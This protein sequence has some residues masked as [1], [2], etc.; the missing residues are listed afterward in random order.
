[1]EASARTLHGDVTDII[2]FSFSCKSKRLYTFWEFASQKQAILKCT[3]FLTTQRGSVLTEELRGDIVVDEVSMNQI[4]RWNSSEA[5]QS[6]NIRKTIW[7]EICFGLGNLSSFE[8]NNWKHLRLTCHFFYVF[9]SQ[10]FE[11][12][13][14]GGMPARVRSLIGF[15]SQS[16]LGCTFIL[17]T[18]TW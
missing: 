5:T 12:R 13:R 16:P 14:L 8:G 10:I 15:S 3:V 7:A 18:W 2:Y 11:G 1:M 9:L 6:S 4:C 17:P